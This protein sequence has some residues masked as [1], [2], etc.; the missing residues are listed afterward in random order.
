MRIFYLSFLLSL[1]VVSAQAGE[2]ILDRSTLLD[3]GL[4]EGINPPPF[5]H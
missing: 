3:S 1:M 2:R 4:S 5:W